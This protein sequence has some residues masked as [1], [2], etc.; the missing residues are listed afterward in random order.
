MAKTLKR[1]ALVFAFVLPL[2][3]GVALTACNKTD[4]EPTYKVT[5][6]D[7][8]DDEELDV[9]VDTNEYK[10]GDKA[11]IKE[12]ITREDYAFTGWLYTGNIV[13]QPGDQLTMPAKNVTLTAQWAAVTNYSVT[14]DLD[15]GTYKG[16][17]EAPTES[18]KL[19]G[20]T[21][22]V[23]DAAE[24][25][26]YAFGGWNDGTK[27]YQPGETY[28]VGTS[29][30]TLKAVWNQKYTVTFSMGEWEDFEGELP[31]EDAHVEGD[32]FMLPAAPERE[33]Y[34]FMRWVDEDGN[35]YQPGTTF[36][37]PAKNV[38]ITAIWA[39]AGKSHIVSFDMGEY[40]GT[41]E[42]GGKYLEG[43]EVTLPE[44]P[45]FEDY[46]FVKWTVDGE[47]YQP[48]DTFEMP[49]HDVTVTAVW[50][51]IIYYTVTFDLGD[52]EGTVEGGKYRAN[53][54]FNLPAA[55]VQ[56]GYKFYG[57]SLSEKSKTTFA[58]L[59]E[60]GS[61][62][63]MPAKD[64][65]IYAIG[66]KTPELGVGAEE[67][68]KDIIVG[69][70]NAPTTINLK[71]SADAS[72]YT[73]N[74]SSSSFL[75]SAGNGYVRFT[76]V[77]G[78]QTYEI[79]PAASSGTKSIEIPEGV[80]TIEIYGTEQFMPLTMRLTKETILRP[81]RTQTITLAEGESKTYK[82][83]FNADRYG[84]LCWFYLELDGADGVTVTAS[85]NIETKDGSKNLA[86][87]K[88]FNTWSGDNYTITFT[89][90]DAV[91]FTVIM[92]ET[93]EPKEESEYVLTV[94]GTVENVV[95]KAD[96]AGNMAAFI[97]LE[98][99]PAGLTYKITI[100]GASKS[101]NVF[102]H[103]GAE[104]LC[105]VSATTS[106]GSATFTLPEGETQIKLAFIGATAYTA[107][108]VSLEEYEEEYDFEIKDKLEVGAGVKVDLTAFG[109]KQIQLDESVGAGNY[110]VKLAKYNAT[111]SYSIS[112]S[113]PIL[114]NDEKSF[115]YDFTVVIAITDETSIYIWTSISMTG[116]VVYL[117]EIEL[118]G[119]LKE[120]E[121]YKTT[122]GSFYAYAG[123]PTEIELDAS[124]VPGV[125]TLTAIDAT[126]NQPIYVG[127]SRSIDD[128]KDAQLK[129][130][131]FSIEL[132]ITE[133]VTHLYIYGFS[134][135]GMS[136]TLLLEWKEEIPTEGNF[137]TE[138]LGVGDDAKFKL[139]SEWADYDNHTVTIPLSNVPAGNYTL[140]LSGEDAAA[141]MYTFKIGANTY[142]AGGEY[143]PTSGGTKEKLTCS[144]VIPSGC[145]SISVEIYAIRAYTF[146]IT[147]TREQ[148]DGLGIGEENSY[149]VTLSFSNYDYASAEVKLSNV[150]AGTYTLT[151]AGNQGAE[152]KVMVNG[153]ECNDLTNLV[154]PEGCE[155][156]TL[157]YY[158]WDTTFD[159]TLTLTANA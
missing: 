122:V 94:G 81:D 65:T 149:M 42:H 133:Q 128:F 147:L 117:E 58:T 90:T 96:G 131:A 30:V 68:A 24:K 63:T 12:G 7:G 139:I 14:Y 52:Y 113:D 93:E 86:N 34:E 78:Y 20:E 120:G 17:S 150:P 32:T 123:G 27:T 43:E 62:Y 23:A 2:A 119:A 3:C 29:N 107:T 61:E 151:I 59:L 114:H 79:T 55:L 144:I 66:Q 99:V 136:I 98:N 45:E 159:I 72:D 11:T 88:P 105:T 54:T 51:K 130:S 13:Y 108:S 31:T 140:T 5:Y 25:V 38:T 21:F 126:G 37:M 22:T 64:V 49:E 89:A 116:A 53:A 115:E 101:V 153:V 44:P 47:D 103:M 83:N 41:F 56:S 155:S 110:I 70:E 40:E 15:G 132:T 92:I 141:T 152:I 33:G 102:D 157:S 1:L 118:A 91:T 80:T 74:I 4:K 71:E 57:W 48:G 16:G 158:L 111:A 124:V 39:E 10:K 104:V 50:N 84:Y 9:P 148:A 109:W 143:D 106:G 134:T 138:V 35:D 129:P 82:I 127:L 154:I 60:A 97:D 87:K 28:T 121:N 137:S 19:E 125:Y 6:V 156:I 85:S 69:T 46:D 8:V 135:S 77:I 95:F 145:E 100:V 26:G 76:I 146:F 67:A 36:V 142:Q 73:L 18:K 112:Y 75:N